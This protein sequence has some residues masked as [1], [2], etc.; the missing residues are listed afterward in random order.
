MTR[1]EHAA[2]LVAERAVVMTTPI[3]IPIDA[4][5]RSNVLDALRDV[6]ETGRYGMCETVMCARQDGRMKVD[7]CCDVICAFRRTDGLGGSAVLD[8]NGRSYVGAFDLAGVA[9]IGDSRDPT[10]IDLSREPPVQHGISLLSRDITMGTDL[11]LTVTPPSD[12]IAV[13]G[14]LLPNAYRRELAQ[15]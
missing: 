5:V 9:R 11:G 10:T 3:T 6:V 2:L 12:T 7:R 15:R 8:V 13:V 1:D 4:C 14:A